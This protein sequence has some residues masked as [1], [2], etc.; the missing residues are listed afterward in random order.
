MA[1]RRTKPLFLEDVE[2]KEVK[3]PTGE[4]MEYIT[5]PKSIDEMSDV[6]VVYPHLKN[7]NELKYH[8]IKGLIIKAPYIE[9]ALIAASYSFLLNTVLNG[10]YE[11]PEPFVIPK[12]SN[13]DDEDGDDGVYHNLP[14]WPPSSQYV[15][16]EVMSI[17]QGNNEDYIALPI[18]KLSEYLRVRENQMKHNN[19]YQPVNNY[20]LNKSFPLII[21]NDLGYYE[22]G[23]HDLFKNIDRFI[24][25]V[26][27]LDVA[28]PCYTQDS[29]QCL[30][31]DYNFELV[32]LEFP[33]VN[34]YTRAFGK[35][36]NK[37]KKDI[38]PII[39]VEVLINRLKV[40]RGSNF[41]GVKDINK[42]VEKAAR[43][44]S[45]DSQTLEEA[46]FHKVLSK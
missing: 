23:F 43:Y 13:L 42:L 40:Y 37:H 12:F 33:K 32:K 28:I 2:V 16:Q 44:T 41:Q 26:S 1:I 15:H 25:L 17:L 24:I 21:Q 9:D 29:E 34:Y 14:G 27:G 5:L 18:I 20:W 3:L 39:D 22:E 46:H 30:Q 6:K 8:G 31:F 10:E 4:Y 35:A 36:L 7:I 11:L 45:Y 19:Q 38:S